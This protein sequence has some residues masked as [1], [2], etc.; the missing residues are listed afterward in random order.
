[1]NTNHRR[2]RRFADFRKHQT[3]ANLLGRQRQREPWLQCILDTVGGV[4]NKS[5]WS[6]LNNKVLS[7]PFLARSPGPL[8]ITYLFSD[9]CYQRPS[10]TYWPPWLTL[11]AFCY[12]SARQI[13]SHGSSRRLLVL[14]NPT[15]PDTLTCVI[16]NVSVARPLVQEEIHVSQED[17]G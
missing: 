6:G 5:L 8:H 10:T 13:C 17:G 7:Y 16:T 2:Q 1:M 11:K 12:L 4:R 14:L 15:T 3:A 9:N